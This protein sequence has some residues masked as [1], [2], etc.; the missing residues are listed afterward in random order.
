MRLHT[1]KGF[2]TASRATAERSRRCLGFGQKCQSFPLCRFVV[3]SSGPNKKSSGVNRICIYFK[4]LQ[5]LILSSPSGDEPC[6]NACGSNRLNNRN[7]HQ[8][9]RFYFYLY[10]F[11]YTIQ[12][13]KR[14]RVVS[15]WW[16]P[17]VEAAPQIS[18]TA[19]R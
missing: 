1:N 10:I 19:P 14:K 8:L 16:M 7:Q 9:C 3:D 11:Y 6:F 12:G 4:T 15:P 2:P 13:I 18:A 17:Q 5:N